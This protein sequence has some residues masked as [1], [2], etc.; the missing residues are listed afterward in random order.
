M[1]QFFE[2]GGRVLAF[3]TK[4]TYTDYGLTGSVLVL[5]AVI[6]QWVMSCRILGYDIEHAVLARLVSRI[7]R[8][9]GEVSARMIETELNMPC[10]DLFSQAG[11]TRRGPNWIAPA[12]LKV[13]KPD[14]VRVRRRHKDEAVIS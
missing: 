8:Q 4:D 9:A 7:M 10:R 11:F 13:V 12:G 5:G 14:H 2:Q 3:D 6:E 1:Q